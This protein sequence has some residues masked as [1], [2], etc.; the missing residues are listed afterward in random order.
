M[1]AAAELIVGTLVDAGGSATRTAVIAAVAERF[2]RREATSA[3]GYVGMSGRVVKVIGPDGTL[4]L[5][6]V[7]PD[8]SK[9]KGQRSLDE[10]ALREQREGA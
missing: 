2:G 7:G 1:I 10:L 6:L 9:L 4:C 3:L 8:A 5:E